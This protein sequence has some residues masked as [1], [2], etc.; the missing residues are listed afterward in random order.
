MPVLPSFL[1]AGQP[2]AHRERRAGKAFPLLEGQRS[3]PDWGNEGMKVKNVY[4]SPI[5]RC[6]LTAG[7]VYGTIPEEFQ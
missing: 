2:W 1:C 6:I 7:A 4:G 3:L 5:I